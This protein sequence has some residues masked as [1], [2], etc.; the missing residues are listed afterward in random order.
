VT[1]RRDHR[2]AATVFPGDDGAESMAWGDCRAPRSLAAGRAGLLERLVAAVRPE[3]RVELLAPAP[4]DP[5]LGWKICGSAE[6]GRAVFSGTMCAAH[7]RRWRRLGQPEIAKFLTS[8]GPAPRGQG[9]AAVID[10]QN[11]PPQLKLEL[12][13]AVQCRRDEQTVTAPFRVVNMAIGWARRAGV[14]SMLDLSEPQWR[15]LARSTRRVF[16]A[17]SGMRASSESFLIHARDAVESL[18]DGVGWEAEYPRDVWRLS[19]LPGLTLNSGRMATRGCLRFDQVSQPWLRDLGKRWVR[20]RL[21]S[22][23]SAATAVAGVQA[24]THFSEFLAVAA[25]GVD[26]AGIDRPLLERYLAWLAGRAGGP[27]TRG[28]WIGSLNQFFQAIRRYGWDDTLPA[29]AAM[30]AGDCP[31]RPP[32]LTR[33][34]AEYVMAQVES[35]ASLSRWPDPATR[36]VTLILIRCG[37]RACDACTLKFDCLIYDG[38]GAPYLRY[39]NT[40]MRREAAVPIDEE[41]AAGIRAQQGRVAGRWPGGN[42]NLFPRSKANA[43]GKWP[44]SS[45]SYRSMLE[46]WLATCDVR[47]EHGQPVHL[48]AHQWRHTFACRLVN[49]DVPQEVIRVLLDHESTQMTAHYAR[50][51]DQTVR[52]HWEQATR[53]NIKGERVTLNP[54]G[55]LGQAQWARTRYGMATQTLSNGYCGLPVQKSCPHA[56]ACLTCPVFVSGPEFLPELREQRHRTLTLIEVSAGKGQARVAEMNQQVLTNLD[57]MI[58]E[59]EKSQEGG[60]ADAG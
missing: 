6:C 18:R 46:R 59:I 43:S 22:G 38:Q 42:P 7:N 30:F 40:K 15:E 45:D 1:A 25:P 2:P 26:L 48:T 49:R 23:L 20:L 32:R 57:R 58:S 56:N 4:G 3:F 44:L 5:V 52:R 51:T 24:L 10:Y 53:V 54:D 31:P 11:L 27:A 14:G 28:R 35:P 13:Y 41:L 55:P 21:C 34:L 16:A 12:Q 60:A 19:R 29:T 39:F 47:D 8:P 17:D 50:I 37:L 9:G 36:L 33:H